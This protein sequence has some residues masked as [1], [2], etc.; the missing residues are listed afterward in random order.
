LSYFI[1][2]TYAIEVDDSIPTPRQIRTANLQ[3]HTLQWDNLINGEFTSATRGAKLVELGKKCA[4][5]IASA[6][7]AD[8]LIAT[9]QSMSDN[10]KGGFF[11]T[12]AG[13]LFP[14]IAPLANMVPF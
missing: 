9:L 2:P 12:L 8:E 1:V 11:G 10:T 13:T 3:S 7:K 5:G 14:E 4:P 6:G